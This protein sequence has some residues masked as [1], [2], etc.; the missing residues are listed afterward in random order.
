[1]NKT[2]EFAHSIDPDEAAP[3]EY[4]NIAEVNFVPWLFGDLRA[5][6]PKVWSV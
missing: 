3:F 2:V 1:M 4:W 6:H 5:N